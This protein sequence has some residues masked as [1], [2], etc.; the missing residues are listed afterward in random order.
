MTDT[1]KPDP[2]PSFEMAH[3]LFMD[4]VGYS[5]MHM[6]RQQRIIHDLQE[7]VRHT[8]AFRRAQAEDQ[9][10]KL[11]S[12]DGMA[13]VFFRDP[14]APLRCALELTRALHDHPVI[15]LRMG[16]HTGPVYRVADINANSNV[17]G[18][19]INIAQ[20]V[21]D[22]G[23]AG[24]IL[25][26]RTHAEV[27]GQV[28]SWSAMLHDLGEAAVKH[29]VQLH[30]YNVHND[31]AGNPELPKKITI[32]KSA[33][34]SAIGTEAPQVPTSTPRPR[35]RKWALAA[36][37]TAILGTAIL[38]FLLSRRLPSPK[39]SGYVQ[40]T[41][42]T[43]PKT[44]VGTDG[45][46]LYLN[47]DYSVGMRVVQISYTGGV[48]STIPTPSPSFGLLALSPDGNNLLLADC[49]ADMFK[50]PLWS[51]SVLGGSRRRLGDAVGTTG[52]WS[53]DGQK[54][55]YANDNELVL[56]KADGTGSRK[57]VS[58][59]HD[60]DWPAWAPDGEVIRFGMDGGLWEISAEGTNLHRLFSG[61]H[62]PP[63][64]CCG[65]WTPDGRFF[66]FH[67][68]NN[69]W[70]IAEGRGFL[71]R[72]SNHPVKLTDGPMIYSSVVPSNDGKRLFVVGEL[73][74]GELVRYDKSI[75]QFGPFLSGI[76]AEGVT[77][78]KDGKW[79][80]YV[81]YPEG[82]LWRSK[83]DGSDRLQ[84]S[85]PPSYA[86]LPRWSPDSRQIVFQSSSP[87]Q[88]YRI[89]LVSPDSASPPTP[90][91]G[92]QQRGW[93]EWDP[94]WSP[95]GSKIVFGGDFSDP[96]TVVRIFDLRSRQISE[97]PGSKGLAAPRWSP[98]GRY[99]AALR[100][101]LQ[102]IALFDFATS[103]WT[104]VVERTAAFD[105][106]SK[107]GQYVYFLHWPD[108]SSVMRVRI[109]DRQLQ[110]VLDLKDFRLTGYYGGY[111]GLGQDD[112]PLLLRDISPQEVYALD[113]E[114]P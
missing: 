63:D 45:P 82:S 15:K 16:V 39:V 37:A 13:L 97:L 1:L 30:L 42:D 84:L 67:S 51:Q 111:L 90:V 33:R 17:A 56:A 61:W 76:S 22:C 69:I 19:G 72:A 102:G 73:R 88:P 91:L 77:F 48:D 24:H 99:I 86:I 60:V 94:D 12:G 105:H 96:N 109:R 81:A 112:S 100:A 9:L 66:L 28:S 57:L 85:F 104:V 31:E 58:M 113:W 89:Y 87:G 20:R 68:Q 79:V 74:R 107:D 52:A 27:L 4:I 47:E 26:S 35:W 3:V 75:G 14:E 80:A 11:P 5:T 53:P 50:G 106:W 34:S 6:D 71:D 7:A 49:P 54:L 59:P 70:A 32:E 8:S 44:L 55:V 83:S 78:S 38:G 36:S 62:N 10:I 18:G 21:M 43:L 93:E 23:D 98:D 64:E 103:K 95:D 46:R 108:E 101:N 41:H 40:I 114:A 2:N 25:V 110:T 92:N 29:G 65:K